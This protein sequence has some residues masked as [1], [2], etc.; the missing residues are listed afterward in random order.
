MEHTI[1]ELAKTV[2]K[3]VGFDGQFVFD[4]TKPDGTPRKLMDNSRIEAMGWHAQ[5]SLEDGLKAAYQDYL[6][7]LAALPSNKGFTTK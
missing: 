4:P 5:T 6:K 1:A 7:T 2:A 3:V